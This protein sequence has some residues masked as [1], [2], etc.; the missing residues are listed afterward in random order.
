MFEPHEKAI[1]T[2]EGW[3]G[4][5]FDPLA[6][7]NALIIAS[8]GRL[9]DLLSDWSA[10]TDGLGD[11]SEGSQERNAVI[12]AKAELELAR[13]TRLAFGLPEFPECTDAQALELLDDFARWMEGKGN[14]AVPP[15][16]RPEPS[17]VA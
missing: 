16:S 1:Y 9:D 13:I 17:P 3:Q 5:P 8:E 12:A 2:P 14:R 4:T 11:V 6:L 15:Q 10:T 7:H